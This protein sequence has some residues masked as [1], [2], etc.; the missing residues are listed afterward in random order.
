MVVKTKSSFSIKLLLT[1]SLLILVTGCQTAQPTG[2]PL[3][4]TIN[5]IPDEPGKTP[6]YWCTWGAQNYAST[7]A[8]F[9][10][11]VELKGHFAIAETLT[12]KS[13]FHN[14]G[15]AK[16]FQ[17][18]RSDL[19]LMFDLGWDTPKGVDFDGERWR[20]GTLELV[21]EK[22]PSCTGTPA[23]RLWKLNQL[24]KN[25]GW[26]GAGIWLASQAPGDGKDG[27]FM[28]DKTL[29]EYWRER[30]RW[31]RYAGIEYWK[32]DYGAR[33]GKPEFRK[34]LTRIAAEE[35]PGLIVEH[36][37]GSGP[38][39][40]EEC[41]WDTENYHRTGGY[42][43]W[44]NG[45]VLKQAATLAEFNRILRTYDVTAYF[46]IPTT[47]DR[48]AQIL[49]EFSGRSDINC[50]INCEDE[51]YIAAVLGCAMG[52]L[53][54]PL[55]RDELPD[56]QYDPFKFRKRIDEVTRAVRWHRI[57]PAF[58]VG[59]TENLLDKDVLIDTWRLR[60]GD[61]WA[62]WMD[63]RE[64]LQTAPARVA[65]NMPL[66]DVIAPN[67]GPAPYVIASRHPNGA[68]SVAA[69][70]R[71]STGAGPYFPLADVSI[72][73][74]DSAAPIGIFGRYKSLTLKLPAE[75]GSCRIFAQDLAADSA[76]DITDSVKVEGNAI[77]LCGK[78]ING[79]GLAAASPG[80]LSEPALV[81]AIKK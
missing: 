4:E 45:G 7:D 70:P 43:N 60:H 58:A 32:V 38:L 30:A 42:R 78:L 11:C 33:G 37:R 28:D 19:F 5:L 20:L 63:G 76:L 77:T 71:I 36:G 16:Y 66:P 74:A 57:A 56:F 10:Y 46:S 80:D 73:I 2:R 27:Q 3:V 24:T 6:S 18:A 44:D 9:E 8:A 75:P 65:R 25:A 21:T 68:T 50:I 47:L 12:E 67:K 52:I 59:K 14:P 40:D 23:Q 81:L 62:T 54:H 79:L 34:M 64:S 35:A 26:R 15:W 72:E 17:K 13:V 31:T 22:F 39:N 1:L 49:A 41:P 29:D 61:S 51:P 69:L 55:W 53:R 48:V